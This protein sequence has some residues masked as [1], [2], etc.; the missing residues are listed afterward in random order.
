MH[1]LTNALLLVATL[2]LLLFCIVLALRAFLANRREEAAPF[3]NYFGPE[4]DRDLLQQS[5]WSE[6]EDGMTDRP[7][8]FAPL[9]LHDLGANERRTRVSGATPRDREWE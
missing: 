1:H 8:R 3:R 7:S 9:L 2:A 4:Y 5:S 6:T